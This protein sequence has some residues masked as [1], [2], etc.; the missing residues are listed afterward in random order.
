MQNPGQPQSVDGEP[1]VV[2][3]QNII[4][5]RVLAAGRYRVQNPVVKR[6]AGLHGNHA[7]ARIKSRVITIR[8]YAKLILILIKQL[9]DLN[10][11]RSYMTKSDQKP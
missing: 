3:P 8:K 10:F 11:D 1:V 9:V 2:I 6:Y 5:P 4:C 7:E